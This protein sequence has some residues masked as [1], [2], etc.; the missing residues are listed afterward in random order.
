VRNAKDGSNTHHG[1]PIRET[2][3]LNEKSKRTGYFGVS[4]VGEGKKARGCIQRVATSIE[5]YFMFALRDL[6]IRKNNSGPCG[7]NAWEVERA[8][9]N[10]CHIPTLELRRRLR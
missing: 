10:V 2:L 4:E 9:R 6:N 8:V 1:T 5:V 3:N 7:T